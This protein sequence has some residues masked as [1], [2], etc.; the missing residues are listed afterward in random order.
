MDEGAFAGRDPR[1][2]IDAAIGWWSK[3]ISKIE[4]S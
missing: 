1:E 2:L 3:Q 4:T